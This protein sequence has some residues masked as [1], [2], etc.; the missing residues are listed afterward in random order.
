VA[1]SLRDGTPPPVTAADGVA[2]LDVIERGLVADK[3]R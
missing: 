3:K 2:V 1:A